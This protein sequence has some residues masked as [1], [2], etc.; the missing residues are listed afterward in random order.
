MLKKILAILLAGVMILSLGTVIA[1]ADEDDTEIITRDFPHGDTN[2]DLKVNIKDAT[3]IQKWLVGVQAIDLI[4]EIGDD[5]MESS[6]VGDYDYDGKITV[7]DATAIQK[8]LAGI[9]I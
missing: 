3:L 6:V 9:E 4:R 8:T 5:Y 7:R 1:F 2:L